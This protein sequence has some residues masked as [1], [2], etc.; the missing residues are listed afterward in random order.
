[1]R[2]EIKHLYGGGPVRDKPVA[3]DVFAGAGG[4]SEGLHLA[5]WDIAVAIE[6]DS[7]AAD[8]YEWN[9]NKRQGR[10]TVILRSDICN[11][12]REKLAQAVKEARGLALGEVDLVAGGPP[13]QGFSCIGPRSVDD[14]RNR[15]FLEFARIICLVQ[16]KIFIVENVRGILSFAQGQMPTFLGEVFR[17][18]G[19][20]LSYGVI[21]SLDFG[22]PQNRERVIFLGIR[23]DISQKLD[24]GALMVPGPCM[25][26]PIREFYHAGDK[27]TVREALSD[28]P[29]GRA[30]AL[31][32]RIWVT[33]ERRDEREL[34]D[35][36]YPY[37]ANRQMTPYQVAMR[38]QSSGIY[39]NHTKGI[40]TGRLE[41]V[42]LIAEG[43]VAGTSSRENSWRRLCWD[44]HSHTLQAHMGK[45]LKEFIHPSV[46]RWITV[47][48]AARL[49][50][51][52]DAYVFC[53]PQN[54]QLSQIG[55][56]VPPFVGWAVGRSVG[57]QAM[58]FDPC[59]FPLRA[60]VPFKTGFV[61]KDPRDARWF[62][63]LAKGCTNDSNR[64]SWV[65]RLLYNIMI[66]QAKDKKP[67]THAIFSKDD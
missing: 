48:E 30:I 43:A 26:D 28:L 27:I 37:P 47:R 16:P 63:L 65:M 59:D 17:R 5:G 11:V 66:N 33:E 58:F 52:D 44:R 25:P 54:S 46:H 60:A 62:G 19:Y 7:Y 14:P 56:S 50:S 42:R 35:E 67:A 3:I 22:V 4:L 24:I 45:D 61:L 20:A 29:L 41:K 1:M 64:V 39:N 10:N 18:L 6:K 51:Y 57:E 40:S 13:C 55:N 31:E 2:V 23:S 38:R 36:P 9:Q 21:N 15:L 34:Q 12:D 8:T 53:G 32:K 49:Q